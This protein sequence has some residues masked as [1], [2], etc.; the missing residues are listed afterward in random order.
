M[1]AQAWITGADHGITP[2][3]RD[4]IILRERVA[5][6][7]RGEGPRVGD[8]IMFSDGVLHRF[9]HDWGDGLQTSLGGSFYLGHGSMSFSGGLDPSIPKHALLNSGRTRPGSA[10]FFHCDSPRA[11]SAIYVEVACRVY[12]TEMRSDHWRAKPRSETA[13]RNA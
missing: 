5:T 12:A 6:W 2:D 7:N 9:S 1:S 11:Y 3:E 8:F 13:G 4:E 10:W